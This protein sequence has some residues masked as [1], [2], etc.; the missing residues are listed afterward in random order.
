LLWFALQRASA[1]ATVESSS[2]AT[3]TKLS[4][5]EALAREPQVL[6]DVVS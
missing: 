1:W 3:S 2:K 4:P 5:S 6:L